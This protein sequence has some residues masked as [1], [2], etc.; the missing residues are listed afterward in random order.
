MKD[1]HDSSSPI[2]VLRRSALKRVA[3]IA[4]SAAIFPVP[5][6]AQAKFTYKLGVSQTD[7]HPISVGLKGAAAEILKASNGALD[8]QVFPNSQLGGD[9]DMMSQVRSGGIQFFC[10]GGVSWGALLPVASI[11]AM[12][13][14]FPDYPSVWKALDGDLGAHVRG[15]FAKF[16]LVPQAKI[17]DH[18]FRHITTST[19]AINAPQ[20]LA[21]FKIRVPVS[22]VLVSLFKGIGA[23][24][25]SMNYS[26]LYTALQTK[27]VEGQENPLGVVDTAK[28]Y[29]VQ[30]YCS[31]TSHAWDGQWVVAN[32]RA[33]D[34]LPDDLRQLASHT[35]DVFAEKQR[36][37]N[38]AQDLALQESLKTRGM[39]FNK[40]DGQPFREVLQKS[41]FYQ[42]WKQKLGAEA[43]TI[44]EK[45]TGK[46]A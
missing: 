26:E 16:N 43:W 7:T 2:N 29:E 30:K 34:A 28:L 23:S 42:E 37:A 3:V 32:K 41:G 45:Y 40:V 27:I 4:G 31:L 1:L 6:L 25:A 36:A 8:I 15:Q 19:K 12:A 21:N 39:V 18:G 10:L 38:A 20:D 13:F 22:P 44:L 33:W 11:H 5:V 46:L 24:P 17:W 35:F 14:A 9:T